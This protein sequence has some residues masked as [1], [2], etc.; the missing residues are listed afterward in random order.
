MGDKEP[1]SAAFMMKEID[2]VVPVRDVVRYLPEALESALSQTHPCKS[3]IVIDAGS[4]IPISLDTLEGTK[5]VS[6][7]RSEAPLNIAE[8]RNL[9]LSYCTSSLVT[10]L[11]GDDIWP[12]SRNSNLVKA[13]DESGGALA[14]GSV[15][16]F[17]L[18]SG[19]KE[20]ANSVKHGSLAG[21][22]LMRRDL[23]EEIGLFDTKL[24]L[25]EY[26]DW[27][28]RVK[29]FGLTMKEI[30]EET[31]WRRVHRE[32]TTALALMENNR[33]DYLKVVRTWIARNGS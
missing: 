28:S 7:I 21:S 26:V 15:R 12:K 19:I 14:Y 30:Q 3:V 4:V 9:G 17:V 6:L 18:R 27:V 32:S 2:V 25:G 24:K 1:P 16:N 31:L 22:S 29:L 11:D 23:F 5:S 8:A 20:F 33:N 13:L 10:F